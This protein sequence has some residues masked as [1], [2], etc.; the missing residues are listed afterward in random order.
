VRRAA[1]AH[2]GGG[3]GGRQAMEGAGESGQGVTWTLRGLGVLWLQ[4]HP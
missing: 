4:K 1:H 2:T 3:G